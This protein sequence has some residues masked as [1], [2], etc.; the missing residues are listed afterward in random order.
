MIGRD[1]IGIYYSKVILILQER[2]NSVE[3]LWEGVVLLWLL[4]LQMVY[5]SFSEKKN[6][7]ILVQVNDYVGD[8]FWLADWFIH[9]VSNI[10]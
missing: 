2:K 10:F 4:L 7:L 8:V 1:S 6:P 9:L 3:I 5:M